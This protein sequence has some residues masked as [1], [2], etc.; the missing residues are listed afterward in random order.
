MEGEKSEE[1]DSESALEKKI[2]SRITA[3]P[4]SNIISLNFV[5]RKG[6]VIICGMSE[7]LDDGGYKKYF[8]LVSDGD[9]FYDDIAAKVEE[10]HELP[11]SISELNEGLKSD[12]LYL[13]HFAPALPSYENDDGAL[14]V[15]YG[16]LYFDKEISVDEVGRFKEV[17]VSK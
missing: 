9:W 6:F 10:N 1:R 16:D 3:G 8:Q 11:Y 14:I 5:N 17:F 4:I 2:E 12:R 13:A 7:K 15:G